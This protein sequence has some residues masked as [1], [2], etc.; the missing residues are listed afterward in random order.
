MLVFASISFRALRSMFN[1]VRVDSVASIKSTEQILST[2]NGEAH[3]YRTFC[4]RKVLLCRRCVCW[5]LEC[6]APYEMPDDSDASSPEIPQTQAGTSL[7]GIGEFGTALLKFWGSWV[8]PQQR[9]ET[10]VARVF[11]LQTRESMAVHFWTYGIVWQSALCRYTH[12][13]NEQSTQWMPSTLLFMM[14]F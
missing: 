6:C 2:R 11:G 1:G 12:L 4:S 14:L 7:V 8:E 3:S 10:D 9:W 13:L 5:Q